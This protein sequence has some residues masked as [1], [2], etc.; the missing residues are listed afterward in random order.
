VPEMVEPNKSRLSSDLGS[1]IC[2]L[3]F[4]CRVYRELPICFFFF[5]WVDCLLYHRALL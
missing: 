2:G 3:V 5:Q 1:A 4:G